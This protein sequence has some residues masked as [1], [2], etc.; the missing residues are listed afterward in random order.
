[1]YK[2]FKK[3]SR[4]KSAYNNILYLE[5]IRELIN[6]DE[7]KC[8]KKARK[9]IKKYICDESTYE[10]NIKDIKR[11]EIIERK[12]INERKEINEGKEINEKDHMLILW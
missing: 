5:E 3:Y 1:M 12:G 9:I 7:N 6:L 11:N 2:S 10:L 8:K 4:E